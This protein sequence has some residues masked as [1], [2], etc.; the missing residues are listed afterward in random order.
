MGLQAINAMGAPPSNSLTLNDLDMPA[1]GKAKRCK[2]PRTA[3]SSSKSTDSVKSTSSGDV[4]GYLHDRDISMIERWND[5]IPNKTTPAMPAP[6]DQDTA[7]QA[8]LRAK[9]ALLEKASSRKGKTPST[10]A[11]CTCICMLSDTK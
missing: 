2:K 9:A 6:H 7:V 4:H 10:A 3:D 1:I 8:Y 11:M 5:K